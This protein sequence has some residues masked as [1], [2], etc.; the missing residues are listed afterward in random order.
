MS[1]NETLPAFLAAVRA[2]AT[3]RGSKGSRSIYLYDLSQWLLWAELE[4]VDVTSPSLA[5]VSRFKDHLGQKQAPL[6]VRRCLSS[7]SGMYIS[8]VN[9]NPPLATWNPFHPK[10]LP[11]PASDAYSPTEAIAPE[12]VR[13]II[14][15]AAAERTSIG[16]RD[17][18]VLWI[19]Y[20]TGL[21]RDS[22]AKLKR[23]SIVSRPGQ[24][25]VKVI[26]K[27]G[28][29]REI[30][31]AEESELALQTWLEI[32]PSSL[33]VFPAMRNSGPMR[34]ETVNKIVA[35]RAKAAGV[36]GAHPHSFRATFA[37]EALDAGMP[38]HEV[39]AAMHHSNPQ[40]TLRYDRGKRGGGVTN[41]LAEYR[42][43][44]RQ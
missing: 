22:V 26:V 10:A 43:K 14:A 13:K 25:V 42:K 37:T 2:H 3:S 5:E 4:G 7:L 24:T 30:V 38:L 34:P 31:L 16:R 20:E 9:Q 40:T 36:T 11:R 12:D 18:A 17:E 39:Q 35:A 1:T 21:R 33:Y 8:A 19:L 28:K 29:R 41:A 6:T 44:E 27:G 23:E 15:Q 32:A